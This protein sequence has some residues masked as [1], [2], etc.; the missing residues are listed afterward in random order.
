MATWHDKPWG[1]YMI[2]DQGPGYLVKRLVI[3]PGQRT[4]LQRHKHREEM[5]IVVSG[6]G[7]LYQPDYILDDQRKETLARSGSYFIGQE[8]WH[9]AECTSTEPLVI[10]E[11]WLGDELLSE[12]DIERKEDDYGRT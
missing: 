4:S 7:T 3:N 12:D 1:G 11:T 5:W 9:R 8:N 10:I 2:L 6:R